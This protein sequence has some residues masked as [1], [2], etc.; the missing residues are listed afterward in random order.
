MQGRFVRRTVLRRDASYEDA[1]YERCRS[2]YPLVFE[3]LRTAF[4]AD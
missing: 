3:K 1:L 2:V 4:N